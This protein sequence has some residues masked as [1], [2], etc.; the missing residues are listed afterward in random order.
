MNVSANVRSIEALAEF[1]TALGQ[2][3][4][5]LQQSLVAIEREIARVGESLRE[6][7][8]YCQSKMAEQELYNVQRWIQLVEQAALDYQQQAH[9][10]ASQL[11]NDMPK[12]RAF[13]ERKIAELNAYISLT[14]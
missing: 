1:K 14:N 3:S 7:E 13:L 2:F 4:G 9:K 11:N 6:Y 10:L 5:D 8:R 12:A